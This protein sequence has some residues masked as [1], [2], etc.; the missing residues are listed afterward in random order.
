MKTKFSLIIIQLGLCLSIFFIAAV[1]IFFL[2]SKEVRSFKM[3]NLINKNFLNI[4][5]E[6]QRLDL[7]IKISHREYRDL[8]SGLILSQNPIPG[9]IV[10]AYDKLY[11]T[12]NQA[13]PFLTM[14]NL[15]Y[16]SIA[17]AKYTISHISSGVNL[18]KLKI[19]AVGKLYTDKF[20][21]NTVIAQFPPAKELVYP[22]NDVYLLVAFNQAKKNE[23]KDDP[24][25]KNSLSKELLDSWLGQ[26]FSVVAQYFYHKGI[27]YRIGRF[28]TPKSKTDNG[29][30]YKIKR[31]KNDTLVLDVYH[32]TKDRPYY[33]AYKN[34]TIE[35][36]EDGACLVE[37]V[38]LST[39]AL[40]DEEKI[41]QETQH[42]FATRKH[43]ENEKVK[44]LFYRHG[45]IRV[46]ATCGTS[47]VY[48]KKFH[49]N[50]V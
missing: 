24:E 49:P 12:I 50:E 6:L 4:Y 30:V 22:Q 7:R 39:L 43:S 20:P 38:A 40:D 17:N 8:S 46:K 3:P 5:E 25:N 15:K 13:K 48:S 11:L 23:K 2:R 35:L 36:D 14:P 10:R 33:S 1:F 18:Y 42:I 16:K 9:K 28:I 21:H 32:D 29:K 26:N 37:S 27:D 45:A 47:E 31:L 34:I 44:L 19:A 41:K